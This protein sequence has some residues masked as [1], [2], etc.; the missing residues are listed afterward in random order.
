M[1]LFL[2][3]SYVFTKEVENSEEEEIDNLQVIAKITE[4]C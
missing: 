1:K 4:E 2:E 3:G